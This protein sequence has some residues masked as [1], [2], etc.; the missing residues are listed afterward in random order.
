MQMIMYV[1]IRQE[2]KKRA[3]C[4][5]EGRGGII[6]TFGVSWTKSIKNC[7]VVFDRLLYCW[8]SRRPEQ[9]QYWSPADGAQNQLG[10]VAHQ[11]STN[12]ST[13]QQSKQPTDGPTNHLI[14]R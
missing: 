3:V 1:R 10:P 13:K 5:Y 2:G 7:E 9:S 12:Q 4:D 6:L 14:K 8:V 11:L